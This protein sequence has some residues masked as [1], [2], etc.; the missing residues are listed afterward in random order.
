MPMALKIIVIVLLSLS[1]SWAAITRTAK[2]TA[3][4]KV[5]TNN[6][7]TVAS[8]ALN[9]GDS[10]IVGVNYRT[11][12]V[13]SVVWGAQSLAN[14]SQAVVYSLH[15]VA[16]GTN[17]VVVT[18]SVDQSAMAMFVAAV[19]FGA[20][21]IGAKDVGST[22]NATGTSTTPA[23][24]G[25]ATNVASEIFIGALDTTGPSG[26]AAGTWSNSWSS[27]QRAGTTGGSATS[28]STVQEG[29]K[30]VAATE[31]SQAA[32]TGITS[33]QWFIQHVT[34]KVVATGG[35]V[36]K[37]PIGFGVVPFPR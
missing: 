33:R 15:N 4:D 6:T 12:S 27:G 32:L 36:I 24:A 37:D 29:Y 16:A 30:I 9:S 20:G 13:T 19:N 21:N 2:G 34:Y 17:D 14:D 11:G 5:G 7:L 25:I 35:A 26:D 1:C 23:D 18:F 3:T 8:V 10:I 28:N 22:D 31:T